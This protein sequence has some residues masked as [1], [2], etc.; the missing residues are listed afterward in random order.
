[1]EYFKKILKE[2]L[3]TLLITGTIGLF[4]GSFLSINEEFLYALPIILVI[5]PSLN[6]TIGDISTVLVSRLTS[7]LYLGVIPLK[8]QKSK[9]L[10][11][12]FL[13]LLITLVLSLVTLIILGYSIG[14]V[15]GIEIVNPFLIIMILLITSLML[16]G[17]LFI[18]LFITSIFLF[19][20]EKDPINFLVPIVT[21]LADFLTPLCLIIFIQI[22]LLN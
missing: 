13:G 20:K 9:R 7:H 21:T 6:D 8:I 16:F 18:F 14:S 10:K 3:I 11:E 12:D 5:L 22:F 4:S 17:L 1:M 15:M 2:S 19:K